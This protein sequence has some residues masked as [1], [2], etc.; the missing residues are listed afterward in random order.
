MVSLKP[1]Q[2]EDASDLFSLIENN[3]IYLKQNFP[4][5]IE[6]IKDVE[7]ATSFAKTKVEERNNRGGYYF[8]IQHNQE[9][10]GIMTIKSID[11]RT[12]KA[13]LAYFTSEN[14]QGKGIA[15][16][17]IKEVIDYSF[18]ELKLVKLYAY[19]DPEN[20]GSKTVVIKNGFTL[21]ALIK[22]NFRNGFGVLRDSEYYG[23]LNHS[24]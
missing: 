12:P 15:T 23:L 2:L 22:N 4:V 17:S 13:E 20:I 24:L 7:T 1:I 6:R 10:C 9:I 3:R 8:L 18:Q 21:E 16:A 14:F 5:T 11:W 19:I